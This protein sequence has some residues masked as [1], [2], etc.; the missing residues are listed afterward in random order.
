MEGESVG[1]AISDG[2]QRLKLAIVKLTGVNV[3]V[4][5]LKV[6]IV[7]KKS[8]RDGRFLDRR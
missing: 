1:G 2:V 7:M 4:E 6:S 3:G 5:F 8:W